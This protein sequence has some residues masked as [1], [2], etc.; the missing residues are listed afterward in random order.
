MLIISQTACGIN[1]SSGS[2]GGSSGSGP[3]GHN[4]PTEGESF[5]EDWLL[6]TYC[7]I[8]IYQGNREDLIKDAF[9][10]ARELE[11][12]LS[13]TIDS[14][15]VARFNAGGTETGITVFDTQNANMIQVLSNALYFAEL[16]DGLFDPTIGAVTPLWDFSSENPEVPNSSKIKEA[17]AHVGYDKVIMNADGTVNKAEDE[18]K[19]DLGAIAKG[20]IADKISEYLKSEDVNAAIIS[21]GGNIVL[22][23]KKPDGKNWAVGIEK[24][25]SGNGEVLETRESV[26]TVKW[27]GAESKADSAVGRFSVVTSGT[28]ER[29]FTKD[30]V[31]YHHVLDPSTGYPVDT[32]LISVTVT[33][34]SSCFCDALSTSCL[35]MGS[36]KAE[37][38]MKKFNDEHHGEPDGIMLYEYVFIKKDGSIIASAGSDFTK[39]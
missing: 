4:K 17:A 23:G 10:Y 34:S 19:I 15:S 38:F 12:E 20:Y 37:E 11:G 33:G 25:F 9:K 7:Y 21:L 26:G 39:K 27:S 8:K 16:T 22:I 32:D 36:E 3:A 24:P 31:L 13:R 1:S 35:L 30:G 18:V 28:Y 29:C 5:G 2:S 6:D 14:S